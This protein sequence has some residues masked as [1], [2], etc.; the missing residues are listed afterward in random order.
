MQGKMCGLAMNSKKRTSDTCIVEEMNLRWGYQQRTK[1]EK[2]QNGDLL[3]NSH[4]ILYRWE[5]NF[6]Q[7]LN[8]HRIGDVRKIETHTAEPLVPHHG[9]LELEIAIEILKNYK[10]R[11]NYQIPAELIQKGNEI[12]VLWFEIHILISSMWNKEEFPE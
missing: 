4:N 12:R 2:D 11:G 7:L 3:A 8:V 10:S 5:I 9:P 1:L 6:S